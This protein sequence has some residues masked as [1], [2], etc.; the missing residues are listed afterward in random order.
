MIASMCRK[1]GASGALPLLTCGQFTPGY[2][3]LEDEGGGFAPP[4][5]VLIRSQPAKRA[6]WVRRVW[7]ACASLRSSASVSSQPMQPSVID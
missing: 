3:W 5:F 6:P 2:F 1:T 7:T 4:R